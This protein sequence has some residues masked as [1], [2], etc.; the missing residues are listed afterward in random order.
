MINLSHVSVGSNCLEEAKI[1]YSGL[2]ELAG[3]VP[4]RDG[5]NGS[6][7]GKDGVQ[8]FAVLHPNDKN[9]ATAGNGSMIA[10]RCDNRAEVDAFYGK[11]IEL[12]GSDAG[13]P[14]ERYPGYYYSYFRDLDGNK[15][16]AFHIAE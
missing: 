9:P 16:C 8:I 14:G 5:A 6:I 11:A 12:G 13:A 2:L 4:L 3:I 10:F 7:F 15:I 1:F